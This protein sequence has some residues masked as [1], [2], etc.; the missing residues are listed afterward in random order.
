MQFSRGSE[1]RELGVKHEV[2]GEI[3]CL[4]SMKSLVNALGA[5]HQRNVA[6]LGALRLQ[7]RQRQMVKR[8]TLTSHH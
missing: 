6:P 8:E 4:S 5:S 1:R 2:P 7:M 3:C